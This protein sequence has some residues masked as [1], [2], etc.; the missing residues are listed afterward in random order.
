MPTI[1]EVIKE[2]ETARGPFTF[3]TRLHPVLNPTQVRADSPFVE[4][5]FIIDVGGFFLD[6]KHTKPI[7][8]HRKRV[9]SIDRFNPDL[10]YAEDLR[11]D[12]RLFTAASYAEF[13]KYLSTL[14]PPTYTSDPNFMVVEL[15]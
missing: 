4:M 15:R 11:K 9:I 6:E 3:E 13:E 2:W 7:K 14:T 5:V 1:T 10:Q 8:L 12:L